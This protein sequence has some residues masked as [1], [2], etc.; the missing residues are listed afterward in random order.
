MLRI[1]GILS[2]IFS[3]H[4]GAQR[5]P[6]EAVEKLLDGLNIMMFGGYSTHSN[7]M[8]AEYSAF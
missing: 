1:S 6:N 5:M 7:V 8:M 2:L 3:F 4:R